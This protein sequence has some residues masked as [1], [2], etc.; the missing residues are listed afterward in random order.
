MV[1]PYIFI[2]LLIGTFYNLA[3]PQPKFTLSRGEMGRKAHPLAARI[4]K[5]MQTDDDVGKIAQATPV[6]IGG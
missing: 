3:F 5:M 2:V 4:K 6:M 1:T